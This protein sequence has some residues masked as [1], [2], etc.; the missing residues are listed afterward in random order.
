MICRLDPELVGAQTVG[1][2]TITRPSA[3]WVGRIQRQL[4][5]LERGVVVARAIKQLRLLYQLVIE[6]QAVSHEA[7]GFGIVLTAAN[8]DGV[9]ARA[10]RD[11][12]V[13]VRKLTVIVIG[14]EHA[15]I[16]AGLQVGGTG[17]STGLMPGFLQ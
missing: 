17:D 11:F 4:S 1:D 7:F 13:A 3:A 8:P 5:E 12:H 16:P 14:V 10:G 2:S 9:A 6:E 15:G